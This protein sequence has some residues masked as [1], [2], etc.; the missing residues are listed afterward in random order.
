MTAET[1]SGERRGFPGA[2]AGE[3]FAPAAARSFGST[4]ALGVA[5]CRPVGWSIDPSVPAIERAPLGLRAVQQAIG[6]VEVQRC[7]R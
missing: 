2:R 5:A 7:W 6:E 3:C 1:R 4:L